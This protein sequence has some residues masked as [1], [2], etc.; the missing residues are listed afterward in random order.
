MRVLKAA[1]QHL[2]N[3]HLKAG[4]FHFYR[5]ELGPAADFLTRALEEGA[6]LS[7][8]DRRSALYYL[9]QTRIAAAG[10]HINDGDAELAIAEY[11][12]AL[13]VM[14]SYPD[15]HW[16]LARAL[17]LIGRSGEAIEHF[18]AAIDLNPHFVEAWLQLGQAQLEAGETDAA[19]RSFRR[20]AEE[21][22]AS[23]DRKIERAEK[24][25]DE[26]DLAEAR[27][28]YR[29][30]FE[31]NLEVFRRH[32]D[33]GLLMLRQEKWDDATEE[34]RVA[35]RLR[36]RYA[37]VHNY[38]GVALAESGDF[39]RACQQFQRSTHINP[40]YLVAWLNLAYAAH[41]RD[42]DELARA[43]LDEVLTREDD[44]AP[45]LRLSGILSPPGGADAG[46]GGGRGPQRER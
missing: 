32:F 14:P 37:D 6:R 25:L 15:V 5:G 13:D 2:E 11:R 39:E 17:L 12:A 40:G 29:D 38:L 36:P 19:R 43:A 21:R 20:A 46:E 9:V 23:I 26:G 3:Y 41:A 28:I 24:T 4:I 44:N 8:A 18:E 16:R 35:A 34:L 42:D 31:E 45:A 10:K 1:R 7:N 22:A 33:R 30:A 27:E